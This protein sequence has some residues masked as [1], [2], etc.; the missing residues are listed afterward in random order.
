M[1]GSL[2]SASFEPAEN[3]DYRTESKFDR[4]YLMSD[5]NEEIIEIK[6][7]SQFKKSIKVNKKNT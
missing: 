7:C 4:V 6:V 5:F 2:N 3:T 1:V